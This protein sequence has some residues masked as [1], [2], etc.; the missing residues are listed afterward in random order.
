MEGQHSA[1]ALQ[2][3]IQ[4]NPREHTHKHTTQSLTLTIYEIHV[5]TK[6]TGTL[7][8]HSTLCLGQLCREHMGIGVRQTWV[9]TL[10][11]QLWRE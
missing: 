1:F 7:F 5:N 11:L 4:R 6:Y 8:R 3:E 10:S 9:C 2:E